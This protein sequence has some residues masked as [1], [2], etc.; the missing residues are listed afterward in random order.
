MNIVAPGIYTS[1]QLFVI[2]AIGFA[3]RKMGIIRQGFS[4][5]VSRFLVKVALPVYFFASFSSVDLSVIFDGVWV[6]AAGVVIF[7]LGL[8]A[9]WL[10]FL[11]IPADRKEKRAGIALAGLGNSGYMPLTIL[12]LLP[13]SIPFLAVQYDTAEAAVYVGVYLLVSSPLLWSVGNTLI[14]RHG[15]RFSPGQFFSPPIIG[16]LTGLLVPVAGI[17]GVFTDTALPFY[18][19]ISSLNRLG[20]VIFPMILVTLGVMIAEIHFHREKTQHLFRFAGGI[21]FVRFILLPGL[22]FLAY[23]YLLLPMALSPSILL[24]IFLEA[25]TPPATNFSAMAVESGVNEDVTAFTLLASYIGYLLVLPLYI[26]MFV[27][28]S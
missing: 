11:L 1:L 19:L 16:I 28:L 12:Q 10:V 24:V 18:Y 15:E 13:V 26:I 20:S 7:S 9:G 8:G 25:C 5:M 22:F 3:A 6:L 21:L 27:N 17:G 2:V 14:A 23:R 4:Q